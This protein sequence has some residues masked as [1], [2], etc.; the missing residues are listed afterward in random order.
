MLVENA[1]FGDYNDTRTILNLNVGETHGFH[2]KN[3][4]LLEG[5]DPQSLWVS[6][7]G[8]QSSKT[9]NAFTDRSRSIN[10]TKITSLHTENEE[11]GHE[12]AP[13]RW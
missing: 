5:N 7:R 8:A 12:D 6:P 11:G 9:K 4:P 3:Y 10:Y 1:H 13:Y 2:K